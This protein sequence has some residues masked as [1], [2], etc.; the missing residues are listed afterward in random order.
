M[1]PSKP[2]CFGG[3]TS[4]GPGG[5]GGNVPRPARGAAA[6][7][8]I[9]SGREGRRY[10]NGLIRASLGNWHAV[11]VAMLTVA[12]LGSLSLLAIPID[13]LPSFKAPAVQVLT[14]SS[15]M[16]AAAVEKDITARVERWTGM[17]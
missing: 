9:D 6:N 14:F 7:R 8:S 1:P 10:M 5:R 11:M 16:P 12:L 15:G 13:I 3:A 17:A 2:S 4:R